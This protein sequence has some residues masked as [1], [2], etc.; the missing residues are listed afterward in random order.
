MAKAN[1]AFSTRQWSHDN[2]KVYERIGDDIKVVCHVMSMAD[3]NL[4]AA[5]HDLLECAKRTLEALKSAETD[6]IDTSDLIA[7]LEDAI[8]RA[9][10]P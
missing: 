10:T 5:S 4:I 7:M 9:T 6:G 3:A 2:G 1:R 8:A